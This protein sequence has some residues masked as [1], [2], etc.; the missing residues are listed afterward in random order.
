ME[1]LGMSVKPFDFKFMVW[2]ELCN[3][4]YVIYPEKSNALSIHPSISGL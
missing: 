1:C 2:I 4:Y 3:K